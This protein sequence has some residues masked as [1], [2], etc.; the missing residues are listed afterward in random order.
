MFVNSTWL[1]VGLA[2]LDICGPS[3]PQMMS[4]DNQVVVS[5]PYG[6]QP[7]VSPN[8]GVKVMSIG[9]LSSEKDAA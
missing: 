9:L 2:D 5:T 7:A 4:V 1:Q 8:G 6:W 3:V